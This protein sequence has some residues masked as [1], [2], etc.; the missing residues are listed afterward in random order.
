MTASSGSGEGQKAPPGGGPASHPG[1]LRRVLKWLLIPLQI[2]L[3]VAAVFFFLQTRLIFPGSDTQGDAGSTIQAPP[4]TELLHL[5]TSQGERVVALFGRALNP[6]GSTRPDASTRPTLLYFYGNAMCLSEASHEF[7]EFRRLGFHVMIPDY[8]GYGMSGG[9]PSEVGCRETAETSFSYLTTRP[10]VDR[11]RIVVAGWSLGGA[12]AIDL[13]SR[14]DV[15]GVATFCTFTRL[16]DMARRIVPFLPVSLLLRHRFE[17]LAK[18]AKVGCPVLIGHG[19]R[20][21]II[22]FSMADR[23]A[24]AVQGPVSRVTIDD[25]DHNDFFAVGGREVRSALS[26]FVEDLPRR[27]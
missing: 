10:D 20:D 3:G 6:D 27:P 15:A 7:D 16:A 23:L 22:P 5:K 1:R 9:K 26:R 24:G 4:G 2:Y 13:A 21:Q 19:R 17:N 12:V 8:L 18:I 11:G 25:A 14:H